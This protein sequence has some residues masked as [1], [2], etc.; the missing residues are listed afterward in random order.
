LEA[1]NLL[2]EKDPAT[3]FEQAARM[4]EELKA[5]GD[6][7][8]MMAIIRV[9][10]P[11]ARRCWYVRVLEDMIETAAPLAREA[12]KWE[13]LGDL[14]M[15]RA[16]PLDGLYF[17]GD[18]EQGRSL[19]YGALA[20]E[21]YQRV[22]KQPAEGQPNYKQQ[23]QDLMASFTERLQKEKR[24]AA[25][26]AILR[27]DWEGQEGEAVALAE[28]LLQ[29]LRQDPDGYRDL[30]SLSTVMNTVR[31]RG[32]ERLIPGLRTICRPREMPVNYLQVLANACI[33]AWGGRDDVFRQ[34]YNWVWDQCAPFDYFP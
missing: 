33:Y 24:G 12:G 18:N 22:G 25:L 21:A 4:F 2:F 1:L 13:M 11:Q 32:G 15:Q 5:K 19:H 23:L 10:G 20:E 27:A 8:G 17:G 6:L 9:V 26:L 14:Y 34:C 29:E 7:E 30:P 28:R 3:A 31:L 16:V